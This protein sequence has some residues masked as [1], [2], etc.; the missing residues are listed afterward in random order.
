MYAMWIVFWN[1][2]TDLYIYIYSIIISYNQT[3]LTRLY[4]VH[5]WIQPSLVIL[6]MTRHAYFKVYTAVAPPTSF[7]PAAFVTPWPRLLPVTWGVSILILGY[8][9]NS[10]CLHFISKYTHTLTL[11]HLHVSPVN[12]TICNVYR[13]V[14]SVKYSIYRGVG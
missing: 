3:P 5:G 11:T 8:Q 12:Y 4:N 9:R 7:R 1:C 13:I 2:S 10:I 14:Y 6:T